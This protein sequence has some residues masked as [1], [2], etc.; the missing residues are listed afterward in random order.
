MMNIIIFSNSF[1][2]HCNCFV[3]SMLE[4]IDSRSILIDSC[5]HLSHIHQKAY[6]LIGRKCVIEEWKALQN[7]RSWI[8]SSLLKVHQGDP[9][10][11]PFSIICSIK[12]SLCFIKGL[13]NRFACRLSCESCLCAQ[14][15]KPG[16]WGKLLWSQRRK[17]ARAAGWHRFCAETMT[18]GG[19]CKF[20]ATLALQ[21]I[22]QSGRYFVV[23]WP[24]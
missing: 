16:L 15:Q 14:C 17:A 24:S 19:L 6:F 2:F 12:I 13:Q 10:I 1:L 23:N 3:C 11:F 7:D 5:W 22:P 18:R 20:C 8:F 21:A 9:A 4:L